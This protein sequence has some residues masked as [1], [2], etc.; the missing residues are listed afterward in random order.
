MSFNLHM[1]ITDLTKNKHMYSK[2]IARIYNSKVHR[3]NLN[4]YFVTQVH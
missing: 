3:K 1:Q 4:K 2:P